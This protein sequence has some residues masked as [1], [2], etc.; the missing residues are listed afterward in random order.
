MVVLDKAKHKGVKG[1][2]ARLISTA[3]AG[4]LAV[5]Q[6]NQHV[7]DGRALAFPWASSISASA[8]QILLHRL[9]LVAQG[10]SRSIERCIR[11][12]G[13]VGLNVVIVCLVACC[14]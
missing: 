8:T 2:G 13:D 6:L 9:R 5:E 1:T 4:H 12:C 3:D 7:S 14:V 11:T 10:S